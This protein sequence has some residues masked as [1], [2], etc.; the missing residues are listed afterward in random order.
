MNYY[1]EIENGIVVNVIVA[2]EDFVLAN[3]HKT[4][5][6]TKRDGSIRKRFAGIGYIYDKTLDAFIPPKPFDSWIFDEQSCN[7]NAPIQMPEG[8][9]E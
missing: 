3:S 5:I 2:S 7:W 6:E 1:A 9:Y 8:N 4:F